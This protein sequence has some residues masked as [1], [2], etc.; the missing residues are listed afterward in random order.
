MKA[1]ICTKYGPSEVLQLA[2]IE[3]P[4]PYDNSITGSRCVCMWLTYIAFKK[5]IK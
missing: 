4:T 5:S 2:D 1:V 3:K